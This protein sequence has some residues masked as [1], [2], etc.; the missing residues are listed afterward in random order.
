MFRRKSLSAQEMG[1][2]WAGLREEDY[3]FFS[4][5]IGSPGS[6]WRRWQVTPT[7]AAERPPIIHFSLSVGIY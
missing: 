6:A 7:I 1:T 5:G 4:V 2:D 3:Y